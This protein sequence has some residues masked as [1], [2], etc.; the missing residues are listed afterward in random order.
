MKEGAMRLQKVAV[1]GGAVELSPWAITGMAIGTE[2]SQAQPAAIV[3]GGIRTE[4]PRGIN[5]TGAAG[6]RKYRIGSHRGLWRGVHCFLR[7]QGT[8]ELVGETRK[9]LGLLGAL[10]SRS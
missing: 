8:M 9:R 3:T 2:V 10:P 5:L 6:G 1:A 4:M 7:A